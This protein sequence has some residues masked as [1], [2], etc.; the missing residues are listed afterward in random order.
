MI[1]REFKSSGDL[2]QALQLVRDSNAIA[3]TRE[4]AENF[5]K[6]ARDSIDWLPESPYRNALTQLPEFVL[7]RLY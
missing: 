2:E 5:A 4:L 1:E 6:D 3:R 7:G